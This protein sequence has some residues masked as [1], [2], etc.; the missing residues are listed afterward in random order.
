MKQYEAFKT[1]MEA[2]PKQVA[3]MPL[4]MQ[5]DRFNVFN[6]LNEVVEESCSSKLADRIS[7]LGPLKFPE[8][9]EDYINSVREYKSWLSDKFGEWHY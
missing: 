5:L 6:E 4:H 9:P 3:M 7:E 8:R 1:K 2:I